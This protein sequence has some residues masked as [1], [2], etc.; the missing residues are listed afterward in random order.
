MKFDHIILRYGELSLKGKNRNRFID[1]LYTNVKDKLQSFDKI[2]VK[3][4][5][6]RMYVH[7]NGQSYHEVIPSLQEIFGIQT[8]SVAMATEPTL[9]AMKTGAL[10]AVREAGNP[11]TFKISAKRIDKSFPIHSQQLNRELGGHVLKYGEGFK[12]GCASS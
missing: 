11:K 4:S 2:T 9:E 7:L 3:K 5:F 6:D 1:R 8:I 12:S 10:Q